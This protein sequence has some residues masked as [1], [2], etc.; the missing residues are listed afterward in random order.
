M[1]LGSGSPAAPADTPATPPAQ[2]GPWERYGWLMGCVWLVFLYFPGLA[3]AQ[4][5]A[6]ATTI[7]LGWFG[8]S[9]FGI[10]Y[11]SGFVY[12]MRRSL[13]DGRLTLWLLFA[14]TIAGA[15]LSVPAIGWH[16]SSYLPFVM[17]YSSYL[18]SRLAHWICNVFGI[19]FVTVECLTAAARNAEAPWP[20][21]GIVVMVAAVNTINSWLIH[22]SM[23]A[24]Q[25]RLKLATS[26]G[27]EAVARD[28][29]DLLGHSLTVVKL[30]AELASRLIDRDPEAARAELAQIIDITGEALAGVRGTV[31]GVRQAAAAESPASS[32]G[33]LERQIKDSRDA[34]AVAG[35][36]SEVRGKATALSPS[37]SL[38]ATWILREVTT[39]VLRHA[40][41]QRVR[42]E[43]APGTL[44]VIDDG[45]G[46]AAGTT[47]GNGMLGMRERA[48]AAGATLRI[49]CPTAGGTRV[50]L[51]W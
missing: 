11:L 25:L 14:A 16:V 3:L 28:V 48:A 27:R 4:S 22:R 24:E 43:F 23:S 6:P 30:K 1:S 18:L 20:L 41:A 45:V 51:T 8:L 32:R 9:V 50:S 44:V 12:G 15:A 26:E 49:D 42:V 46:V 13:L 21:L 7:A 2:R 17:A 19:V 10:A 36:S 35:V 47:G 39:N 34:L 33:E 38:V 29:H 5:H 37:Q 40:R 31:T